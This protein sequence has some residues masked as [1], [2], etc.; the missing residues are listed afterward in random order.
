[1]RVAVQ[2]AVHYLNVCVSNSHWQ[3]PG[4]LE[5]R[6]LDHSGCKRVLQIAAI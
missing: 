5:C 1:M 3:P 4:L 2:Q 6:P